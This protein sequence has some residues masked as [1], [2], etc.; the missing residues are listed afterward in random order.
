VPAERFDLW[1]GWKA[2]RDGR[3]EDARASL[4]KAAVQPPVSF[5]SERAE[6]LLA[7]ETMAPASSLGFHALPAETDIDLTAVKGYVAGRSADPYGAQEAAIPAAGAA[8]ALVEVGLLDQAAGLLFAELDEGDAW[9][10]YYLLELT[11]ELR[12]T[13]VSFRAATFLLQTVPAAD[14]LA[15]PRELWQL[16]Y[17]LDYVEEVAGSAEEYDVDP[18]LLYAIM[19]QESGFDANI[20]S[21]AG[22]LGLMQVIPPTGEGIAAALEEEFEVGHLLLPAVSVRFGAYYIS[23]Q[24]QAFDGNLYAALAAYN[25][26][27]GNAA[28]WLEAAPGDPEL[29]FEAIDF[30][31][32]RRYVQQVTEN[33]ADRYAWWGLQAPSLVE[34]P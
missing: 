27:P 2:L 19:R 33:L 10:L 18:L 28:R 21:S 12:L 32:T 14:R 6:A 11:L 15:A 29:F 31:E 13:E 8:V 26:G 1:L 24:L 34:S 7:G 16:A 30:S 22:A 3:E 23:E 5:W 17:P 9:K 25:G 20:G 4:S